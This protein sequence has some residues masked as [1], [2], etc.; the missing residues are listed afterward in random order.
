M[1][2]E[3]IDVVACPACKGPLTTD[4]IRDGNCVDGVLRCAACCVAIPVAKG[5]ILFGEARLDDGRADT[6][7]VASA[8]KKWFQTD[9]AYAAFLATKA[10]RRVYDA[11][12]M[13]Q[14]FNESLRALLAVIEPIRASLRPG[15]TIL[16]TWSRTGWPG[17]WLASIFPEQRLVRW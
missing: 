6:Q 11:Y 2:A 1:H 15:D 12:A 9:E 17:A 10:D 7:W 3:L 13:F 8:S 14:P 5:F 16:D 4:D